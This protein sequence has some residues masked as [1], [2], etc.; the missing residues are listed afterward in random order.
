MRWL[1]DFN[2]QDKIDFAKM[3]AQNGTFKSLGSNFLIQNAI[4]INGIAKSSVEDRWQPSDRV[5]NEPR[6]F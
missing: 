3:S 6:A 5:K 1:D 4:N 2:Y